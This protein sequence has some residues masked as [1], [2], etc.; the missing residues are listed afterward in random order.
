M[1]RSA[2]ALTAGVTLILITS[3][4]IAGEN[5]VVGSKK[6]TEGVILG[7]IAT[8]ALRVRDVGVRHRAELGG[9]RVLWSALVRGDIDLYAE[10]TGTLSEEI[11]ADRDIP[12]Q[13][14]LRAALD[15]RGIVM[16]PSIGFANNYALA[17]RADQADKLDIESIGDLREH[18]KLRFGFSNEFLDR[19]DGWPGLRSSYRLQARPKGFDHDIAYRAIRDGSVDVTD[20]Y[21]TDA[22]I[23]EYG[24]RVLTDDRDYFKN[25]DAA[26]LYRKDLPQQAVSALDPITGAIDESAMRHMNRRAKIA[27]EPASGVAADWLERTIGQSAADASQG[28]LARL[29]RNTVDHL[30]LVGV[31]LAAAIVVAVGFGL[32]AAV[33]PMARQPVLIVAGILQTIPSLA[34]LVIMVPLIGIGAWPAIVALFVYSLLPIVRNTV[35]GISTIPAG[36]RESAEAL[37]LPLRARLWRVYFPLALPSIL[38]GIKTAAVINVGTATLGALVG[39]GGYGQPILTGIRLDDAGM[40]LQ[41]AIPAAVLALMVQGLFDLIERFAVPRGLRR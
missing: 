27:G 4:S 15:E 21:T 11:F 41:G 6:F 16:S 31:S 35:T 13:D 28:W 1:K 40:I 7:E 20:V 25:Y 26:W 5:V 19:E 9:T 3:L 23:E 18:A 14:A 29:W 12:D 33:T 38:A 37:G 10:Y 24:L 30:Y 39:A 36:L 8:Q 2:W 22:E 32:W 17:M 34:L